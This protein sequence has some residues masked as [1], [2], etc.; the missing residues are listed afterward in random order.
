MRILYLHQHFTTRIGSGSTRSYEFARLLTLRG[1][2]VTVITGMHEHSGLPQPD[3][4]ITKHWFEDFQVIQLRVG[5]SQKANFRQRIYIFIRFML[6]ATWIT[7]R[8]KNVD[9]IFATSTPLTIAFPAIVSRILRRRRYVFEVRDLWPEVPIQLGI[10]KNKLLIILARQLEHWAYRLSTH[11]VALS[12][13][14]RDSIIKIGIPPEK[15]SVIPNSSD[16]ELFDVPEE[17]GKA[18]RKA[19]PELLGKRLLIYAGTFGFVNGLDYIVELAYE[20]AQLDSTVAVLLVGDGAHKQS[21]LEQAA[22][23]KVLNRSLWVMPS[24]PKAQMPDL[25][26][27]ADV[28]SSFVIP[29]PVMLANSANKFFDAF[30][31][32]RPIVINYEGW[33]A[34]FIREHQVGLVLPPNRREAA[35]MLVDLLND[36]Q[37]LQQM[38]EASRCVANEFFDR[39]KLAVQLEQILLTASQR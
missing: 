20:M 31:A 11:I 1:H 7:L 10:L 38:R 36:D 34:T 6:L 17:R 3:Q 13:D 21:I 22:R 33:Q 19:H 12:P 25:L 8:E 4:L 18:F 23:L 35:R 9:I 15:I 26:S 5:Y 37:L 16:V 30:A 39:R 32:G 24:V 2:Q 28:T 27:A 29:N 14:M